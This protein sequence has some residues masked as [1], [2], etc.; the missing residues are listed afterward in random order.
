MTRL[1]C[2]LRSAVAGAVALWSL[3]AL[4]AADGV[5]CAPESGGSHDVLHVIDGETLL[6]DDGRE[7]RLIGALAPEPNDPSAKSRDRMLAEQA[8]RA[9]SAL[10]TDR[11]VTLRYEGR[12]RDRYGRVLA[13]VYAGSASDG[14]WVQKRLISDGFARAYSLP[15]NAG[16]IAALMSAE[17]T[18]RTAGAGLW[19]VSSYR[20]RAADDVSQLLSLTGR[21]ALVEGRVADVTRAQRVTYLNFGADWR[22]D[23]TA[24]LANADVDR[25]AGGAEALGKLEGKRVR[26]RGWIERR[27]GP[28]IVLGSPDEIEVLEDSEAASR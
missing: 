19:D 11:A 25:S 4:A 16:C 26:V 8:S 22:S 2:T 28:M 21:F 6:L 17:Q 15:G 20:A 3:S 27:N 23:F 13:Q 10:V 9:L 7:V 12:R 24:S 1:K 18:A 5:P 14:V